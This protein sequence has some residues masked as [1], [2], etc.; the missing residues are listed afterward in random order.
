MLAPLKQS[1]IWFVT[2][3][4]HLYGPETLRQVA[5]HSRTIAEALDR[6]PRIPCRVVFKPVVKTPEEIQGLL[7]EAN[8]SPACVGLITWMH[9]FSPAKM[10]IAGLSALHK[11]LAHLHTQFNRDLPWANDRHGLHEPEPGRARRPRVRLHREPDAPEP[12]G[13]RRPLAGRGRPAKASASGCARRARG[14]TPAAQAR[15]LRRQ[16]ARGGR[17]RGRQGRRAAAVRLGG[18]R[19]RCRRPGGE[20][21]AR[22][23]RRGRPR[24]WPS[25][26]GL[27]EVKA[28]EGRQARQSCARRR[29][30]RSACARSSRKAASP[31]SP[32]PSRTCTASS[33]S[34]GS[35]PS[36]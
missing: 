21:R 33:S 3:S 27:Y 32:T 25:T 5:D 6:S 1:E 20:D 19:L 12:Q 11:P 18:E 24:W 28:L 34:R 17:D 14:P 7:G 13:R 30:S 35:P 31:A 10:W 26:S 8:A 29:A 2:G 4:Q 9:T 22:D 15:P 36:G 16:H 23:R